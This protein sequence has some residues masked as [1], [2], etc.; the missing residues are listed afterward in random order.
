MN[1]PEDLKRFK[2]NYHRTKIPYLDGQEHFFVHNE[3]FKKTLS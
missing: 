2:E 1:L 3:H